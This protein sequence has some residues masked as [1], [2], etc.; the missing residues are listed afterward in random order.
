MQDRELIF[1]I[2]IQPEAINKI[3]ISTELAAKEAEGQEKKDWSEL[4]PSAYH[5]HA[6]VFSKKAAE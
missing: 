2:S 4:V 1:G 5:H 3:T 6:K